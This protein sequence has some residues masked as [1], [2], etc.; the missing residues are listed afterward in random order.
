MR[1]VNILV[2]AMLVFS[3]PM[4]AGCGDL[5]TAEATA[6]TD[7]AGNGA[8]D[9][10]IGN[11]YFVY[12]QTCFDYL[13][14]AAIYHVTIVGKNGNRTDQGTDVYSGFGLESGGWKPALVAWLPSLGSYLM[15]VTRKDVDYSFLYTM[16]DQHRLSGETTA[17]FKGGDVYC[18]GSLD[19]SQSRRFDPGAWQ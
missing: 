2:A 1:F 4:A 19:A 10:I 11:Y 18:T 14:E 5:K 9:P 7:G 3:L 13:S 8:A 6:P 16:D 15:V 17:T 12:T